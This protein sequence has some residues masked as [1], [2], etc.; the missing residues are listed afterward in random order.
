MK[1][2]VIWFCLGM[3]CTSLIATPQPADEIEAMDLVDKVADRI[4][5]FPDLKHWKASVLSKSYRMDKNWQPQKETDVAKIVTIEDKI[6]TEKILRAT[7]TEK[8]V[9]KDVTEEYEKKARKEEEKI[10]KQLAEGKDIDKGGRDRRRELSRDELF[11]FAPEQQ[12]KYD[13]RLLEGSVI[14]NRPV[15]VL[16]TKARIRTDDYYEGKYFIDQDTFDVIRAEIGLA[17][18][19]GPVKTLE[20]TFNF[21]ILPEGYL[22]VKSTKIRI[23]IGLIIKNIR[24]EA[25][26]T[27]HDIEIL[28]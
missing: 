7:E 17:D 3:I 11:P 23:H 20:M 16:E 4:A 12:V 1:R 14:G 13:H 27:Y 6:R 18:N 15:F 24:M 5:S 21:Q 25:E 19:P 9:Q 8:G 22:F 2:K 28:E 26:E 10:R